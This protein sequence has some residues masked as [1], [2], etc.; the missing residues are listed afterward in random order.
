MRHHAGIPG[1]SRLRTPVPRETGQSAWV[2]H[3]NSPASNTDQAMNLF[4]D[5]TIKL[6]NRAMRNAWGRF[7]FRDGAGTP[8]KH[9][10]HIQRIRTFL[11]VDPGSSAPATGHAAATGSRVHE[12][13]PRETERVR[14]TMLRPLRRPG[15]LVQSVG[16]GHDATTHTTGTDDFMQPRGTVSRE[17]RG[18]HSFPMDRIRPTNHI[19]STTD[20]PMTR[21][22]TS[23][24]RNASPAPEN[25][26][27]SETMIQ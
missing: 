8:L 9:E 21:T 3:E 17:T 5:K 4:R 25:L 26:K 19:P 12:G 20:G 10:A 11:S 1:S 23:A 7:A 22:A 27:T 16:V 13:V 15:A 6:L 2:T 14:P 24:R 18:R